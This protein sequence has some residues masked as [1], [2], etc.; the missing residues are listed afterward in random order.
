MISIQIP[1]GPTYQLQHLV[2][3]YNGTIAIDGRIIDEL[4]PLLTAL[5]SSLTIHV[6]TADT[7]GNVKKAAETIA[8]TIHIIGNDAQDEAKMHYIEALGTAQVVSYG[9][10]RND[11]LMLE[12]AALGIGVVQAEGGYAGLFA[13]ADVICTSM[14]DGL[15]L[16]LSPDR[17]R[18]TL[19]N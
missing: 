14:A 16:L 11:I 10:G 7:H 15:H 6:L 9:N 13:A 12:K 4:V 19:R 2:L 3:D 1:N 17:L 8:D 5:R 18:A